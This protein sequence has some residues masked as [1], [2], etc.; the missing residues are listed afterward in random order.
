MGSR[1]WGGET[2]VIVKVELF[3]HIHKLFQVFFIYKWVEEAHT[4]DKREKKS[5]CFISPL[6]LLKHIRQMNL[7]KFLIKKSSL[8]A[9]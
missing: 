4:Y 9:N 7:V 3:S 6:T 5:N 8:R 2:K 1:D